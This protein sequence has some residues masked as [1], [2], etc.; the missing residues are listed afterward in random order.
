[1][2][3]FL[4]WMQQTLLTTDWKDLSVEQLAEQLDSWR[5]VF[6]VPH[7]LHPVLQQSV[8]VTV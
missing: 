5:Q 2:Q 1:M 4:C 3:L 6:E 7:S 8:A